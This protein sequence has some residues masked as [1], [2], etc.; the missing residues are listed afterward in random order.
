[1]AEPTT[2]Q[3]GGNA[4]PS[5]SPFSAPV[6]PA[7]IE[8]DHQTA[9]Q[10][11]EVVRPD[12][13]EARRVAELTVEQRYAERNGVPQGEQIGDRKLSNS[14][15]DRLSISEKYRYAE[16]RTELAS[17]VD[18]STS[19]PSKP[20][21]SSG[22]KIQLA[23]DFALTR[24]EIDGLRERKGLED[25]RKLTLPSDP[26]GYK[27]ELP[28]DFKVPQGIEYKI[29]D[30][31][32]AAA[33]ARQFAHEAGLSQEQFSKMIAI[34]GSIEVQQ[35]ANLKTARDA[36]LNKLGATGYQR[37]N[38]VEN[39]LRGRLG[40][41]VGKAVCGMLVTAKHVEGFERLMR[42]FANGG[43][44]SFQPARASSEP[45][46]MSDAEWSK[47]SYT[48]QKNYAANASANS[49]GRR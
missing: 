26:T 45:A 14:E 4:P 12:L 34:H 27:L 8:A 16:R 25:S 32:P 31:S 17:K 42:D 43:S 48:E 41:D 46:K 1:M 38:A 3:P 6:P 36:E 28:K 29:D 40:E 5:N 13:Q 11:A 18:P 15:Y 20:D 19:D 49:N 9:R 22:E 35:V 44:G 2:T 37:I 24:E 7:Q 21:A 39:F 30:K 33:L 23:D 10:N 47:L